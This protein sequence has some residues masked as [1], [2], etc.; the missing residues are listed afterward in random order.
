MCASSWRALHVPLS[1]VFRE[2]AR[3]AISRTPARL[4]AGHKYWIVRNSWGGNWGPTGDGYAYIW[5]GE[6][7]M[8][9][10]SMAVF[11]RPDFSRG[12]GW[13]LLEGNGISLAEWEEKIQRSHPVSPPMGA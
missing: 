8:G 1:S 11:T 9:I 6:N 3:R 5:R 4:K 7:Q 2:R 10:D 12:A 13:K